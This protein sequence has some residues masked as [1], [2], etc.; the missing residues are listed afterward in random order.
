MNYSMLTDKELGDLFFTEED[1]LPRA[2]V[3]EVLRRG[4]RMAPPL[5][6]IVSNQFNWTRPF[7]EWWAVVHAS[8]L[9][10]AIG[11]ESAV[12]P[13]L[14]ALR[15]ADAFDCDWVTEAMPAMLGRVGPPAIPHLKAMVMDQTTGCFARSMAMEGLGL[16]ARH[17][18]EI[19]QDIGAF[20]YSVFADEKN[21]LDVKQFAGNTLLDL[22]CAEYK[23]PLLAFGREE[24]MRQEED[25]FYPVHF[26]DDDVERALG[27]GGQGRPAYDRD[28]MSFYDDEEIE[29]RQKRWR[30]EEEDLRK[31]SMPANIKI[32]R[33]APCPC[34]SGKKFKKCCLGKTGEG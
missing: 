29:A 28:W 14:R 11:T 9:L 20:L 31:E 25:R 18:P 6:D 23:E 27:S 21:D 5:S 24:R 30:K 3:D 2:A 4:E 22:R 34:G 17:N 1:R 12:V 32:G 15:W 16:M 19:K 7:P 13:L 33:N 8:F 26:D 10:G